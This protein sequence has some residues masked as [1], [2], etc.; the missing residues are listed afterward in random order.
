M[1]PTGILLD[2]PAISFN[3]EN[4]HPCS[5]ISIQNKTINGMQEQERQQFKLRHYE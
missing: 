3:S 4:N 5:L 1:W 2:T